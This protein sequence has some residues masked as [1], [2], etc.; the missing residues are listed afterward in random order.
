MS[1]EVYDPE[2]G[3]SESYI[4]HGVN[5]R[6]VRSAWWINRLLDVYTLKKLI[7]NGDEFPFETA[8]TGSVTMDSSMLNWM[9]TSPTGAFSASQFEGLTVE[10]FFDELIDYCESNAVQKWE[11]FAQMAGSQYARINSIFTNVQSASV[12]APQ[13]DAA[14]A[15]T[16]VPVFTAISRFYELLEWIKSFLPAAVLAQDASVMQVDASGGQYQFAVIL[17]I[18]TENGSDTETNAMTFTFVI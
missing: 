9:F 11:E 2:N 12:T 6:Q 18:V 16:T 5:L 13:M 3:D 14:V 4:W 8:E 17:T 1:E 15:I 7:V 10:G